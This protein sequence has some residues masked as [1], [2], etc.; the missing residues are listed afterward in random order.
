MTANE[1]IVKLQKI[2]YQFNTGEIPIKNFGRDIDI[3]LELAEEDGEYY[4]DTMLRI[5]HNK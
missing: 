4:I 2:V 3:E 5:E 1:L